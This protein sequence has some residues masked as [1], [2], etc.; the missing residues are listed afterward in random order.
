VAAS[1]TPRPPLTV[2]L[3]VWKALFLREAVHR[4]SRERLS[5][6]YLVA[7]PVVHVLIILFIF[8]TFRVRFVGGIDISIWIM[9]GVT[10]WYIFRRTAQQT[11]DAVGTSQALFTYRQVKPIDT[12]LVR[13]GVEGF[14]MVLVT[15]TLFIVASFYG[16]DTLPDDPLTVLQAVFGMWLIGLGFGLVVS[17]VNE[18]IPEISRGVALALIALFFLSGVI[19][20][21]AQIPEPYLS[22]LM[23]NPLLH[24]V[25]LGRQG[26]A[27]YYHSV[28]NISI[29]Y[30]YGCAVVLI[31]FGL[32]LHNRFAARLAM[33]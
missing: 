12:V 10:S 4:M 20:P 15:M 14:L 24:G 28:P 32:A 19:F 9:I 31:F 8:A 30:L 29:L 22:W 1:H 2:M 18:L 3:A 26:F 13:A 16:L 17:V 5:S 23:W 21:V 6:L 25:D 7:E 11:M 33:K 27:T